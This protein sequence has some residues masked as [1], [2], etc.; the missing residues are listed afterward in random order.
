ML[1]ADAC[2]LERIRIVAE[3]ADRTERLLNDGSEESELQ[4]AHHNEIC[5]AEIMLLQGF[6]EE[7]GEACRR[8]YTLDPHSLNAAATE[9]HAE[10]PKGVFNRIMDHVGA[11]YQEVRP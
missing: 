6:A 9:L 10:L 11:T 4:T 2:Q 8:L 7:Y 3:C 5:E 1:L